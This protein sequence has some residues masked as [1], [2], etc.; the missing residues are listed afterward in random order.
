MAALQTRWVEMKACLAYVLQLAFVD[1]GNS[2]KKG[3]HGYDKIWI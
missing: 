1:D 2:Y 3:W